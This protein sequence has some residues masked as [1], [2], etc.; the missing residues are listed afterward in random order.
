MT[1]LNPPSWIR[2]FGF[3]SLINQ[4]WMLK[5]TNTTIENWKNYHYTTYDKLC[6]KILNLGK[7][8]RGCHGNIKNCEVKQ[9]P[10]QNKVNHIFQ[11]WKCFITSLMKLA[12]YYFIF[13]LEI[14]STV[15]P[16]FKPSSQATVH[17]TGDGEGLVRIV[18]KFSLT[19]VFYRKIF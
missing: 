13:T 18:Q 9:L 1:S 12:I 8:L 6:L 15:H 4:W 14:L 10:H 2:H 11:I 17:G 5:C 19:K 16:T 7:P 3:H